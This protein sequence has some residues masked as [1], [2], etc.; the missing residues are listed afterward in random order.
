MDANQETMGSAAERGDLSIR[1]NG[2]YPKSE[3]QAHTLTQTRK[4]EESGASNLENDASRRGLVVTERRRGCTISSERSRERPPREAESG[5]QPE[6]VMSSNFSGARTRGKR[7]C[8]MTKLPLSSA[9]YDPRSSNGSLPF[10][11][12]SQAVALIL[13]EV[14]ILYR[15]GKV[16]SDRAETSSLLHSRS[17][18]QRPYSLGVAPSAP[19]RIQIRHKGIHPAIAV[20]IRHPE[21]PFDQLLGNG[22]VPVRPAGRQQRGQDDDV[23]LDLHLPHEVVGLI[24]QPRLPQ[25][26]HHAAV[27]VNARREPKL[28]GHGAEIF[29]ALFDQPGVAAGIQHPREGDL[30]GPHALLLHASE[31]GHG[32]FAAAVRGQPADH[33]APGHDALLRHSVEHQA[34]APQAPR[35]GVHVDESGPQL[36]VDLHAALQTVGVDGL[37]QEP[38][39]GSRRAAGEQRHERRLVGLQLLA[40]HQLAEELKRL[41]PLAQTDIAPDH[42]RP[43]GDVSVRHFFKE[44]A[45]AT[46]LPLLRVARNHGVCGDGISVRHFLEQETG[47]GEGGEGVAVEQRGGDVDLGVVPRLE[48]VG[49]EVAREARAAEAGAAGLEKEH[50]GVG[51]QGVA[52]GAVSVHHSDLVQAHRF[53]RGGGAPD[54]G[55]G[56]REGGGR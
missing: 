53:L 48:E 46:D 15:P 7:A 8:Q 55:E 13:C 4:T 27:V 31:E 3:A 49:V 50:G 6:S 40:P 35:L 23:G 34:G 22:E 29:P 52:A 1:N 30:V 16:Y 24:Q 37:A 42:G 18:H 25:Q 28:L 26:V 11:F 56:A 32:F 5:E 20:R 12:T 38:R 2:H 45:C 19:Q 43:R 41:S 44:Q 51:P 10:S 14:Q 54:G 17:I 47:V 33:S 39:R 21:D 36:H 9:F